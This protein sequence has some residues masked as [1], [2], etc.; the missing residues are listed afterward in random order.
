MNWLDETQIQETINKVYLNELLVSK[1]ESI[2]IPAKEEKTFETVISYILEQ[3]KDLR[4]KGEKI[5]AEVESLTIDALSSLLTIEAK[6]YYNLLP[7]YA[8]DYQNFSF[9]AYFCTKQSIRET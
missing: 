3:I 6:D 7:Y 2:L 4:I 8:E 1:G 9:L 5:I